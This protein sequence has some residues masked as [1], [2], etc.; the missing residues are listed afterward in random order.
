MAHHRL[1]HVSYHQVDIIDLQPDRH[2]DLVVCTN[3]IEYLPLDAAVILLSVVA[4]LIGTYIVLTGSRHGTNCWI[5]YG[6]SYEIDLEQPP[7]SLPAPLE[8]IDLGADKIAGLWKSS[9]L[10]RL[11]SVPGRFS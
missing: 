8:R 6:Q 1:N 5:D 2:Y 11:A 3:L 10:T 7:L 4:R 9:Q